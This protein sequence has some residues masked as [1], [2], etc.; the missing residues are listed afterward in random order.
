MLLLGKW[1]EVEIIKLKKIRQN[2]KENTTCLC[3]QNPDLKN[4][5]DA[6]GDIWSESVEKG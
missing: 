2:S 4:D 6:K 1:M 5:M 3:T